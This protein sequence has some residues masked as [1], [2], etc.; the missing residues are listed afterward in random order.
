MGEM[1]DR[2]GLVA[3][4]EETL[5]LVLLFIHPF[6]CTYCLGNDAMMLF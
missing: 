6:L 3:G 5:L 4:G 1:R 2:A